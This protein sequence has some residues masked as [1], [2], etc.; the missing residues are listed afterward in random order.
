[1]YYSFYMNERM[2]LDEWKYYQDKGECNW[3]LKRTLMNDNTRTPREK[4]KF[5]MD[6]RR[7]VNR[8]S[9][10]FKEQAEMVEEEIFYLEGCF[11]NRWQ[12]EYY[13]N[14][15]YINDDYEVMD[16]GRKQKTFNKY[17][18]YNE[19]KK[20]AN[21]KVERQLSFEPKP[22]AKFRE[23]KSISIS[24][25]DIKFIRYARKYASFT[26]PQIEILFGIIFFCRMN[27]SERA[28]L[29][30]EFKMKQFLACFDNA[31]EE[32]FEY[33]VSRVQRLKKTGDNDIIYG[34]FDDWRIKDSN[35][36]WTGEIEGWIHIPVTK[37]NNKLDLTKMAH[38]YITDIS[39]KRYC[40][41]C[42][43]PFRPANNRQKVCE[44]CKPKADAIKAKL[45]KTKQRFIEKNG[46]EACCGT[47]TDCIRTDCNNWWEYWHNEMPCLKDMT[48]SQREEEI[49]KMVYN[50][51]NVYNEE[52]KSKIRPWDM[53]YKYKRN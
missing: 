8:Y 14:H 32:D 25:A 36:K 34:G 2:L 27:D 37:Y 19:L 31:T 17:R 35:G 53:I 13:L 23:H 9:D 11:E 16:Y 41:M 48:D 47:C 10:D 4:K 15:K 38:K 44:E 12:M 45:R 51:Q 50:I 3:L 30:S 21:D 5:Y 42:L 20:H 33:V 49:N 24:K 29:N 7:V 39:N 26:V 28:D 18:R 6:N 43:K 22:T 40:E 52:E 1:M 46:K